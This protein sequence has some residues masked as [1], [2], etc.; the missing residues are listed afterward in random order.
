LDTLA[1][2]NSEH[3]QQR[4]VALRRL[5]VEQQFESA[6]AF[7]RALIADA[8]SSCA[9]HVEAAIQELV[10]HCG[11]GSDFSFGVLQQPSR[12]QRAAEVESEAPE[13]LPPV[14]AY[15]GA[16]ECP[17]SFEMEL[18]TLLIKRG[19]AVLDGLDKGYADALLTNPLLLLNDDQLIDKVRARIDHSIGLEATKSLFGRVQVC[20]NSL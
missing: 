3:R 19:A 17:I 4:Y 5:L 11:D 8:D 2:A 12:L 10:R 15:D 16:F 6:V 18:P 20:Q 14:H 13:E 9:L 1:H 7:T